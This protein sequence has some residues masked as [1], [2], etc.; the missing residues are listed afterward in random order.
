[1]FT[2]KSAAFGALIAAATSCGPAMAADTASGAGFQVTQ[3]GENFDVVWSG[4]GSRGPHGGGAATLMGGGDNATIVYA[5]TPLLLQA[6][7][8]VTLTGGGEN[9]TITTVPPAGS[10][11]LAAIASLMPSQPG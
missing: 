10:N 7:R 3:T 6:P 1:M 8:V 11:S 2:L 4:T 9:S 5:D